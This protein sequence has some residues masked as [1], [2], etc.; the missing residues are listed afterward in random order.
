MRHQLEFTDVVG[1]LK[2][3]EEEIAKT[4]TEAMGEATQLLKLDLRD[5]VE[6]AGLGHRLGMA[7]RSN[8]YP[9]GRNSI[10]AA[11]YVWTKVPKIIDAFDRG[12][13]IRSKE[14]RWLAIP[15]DAAGKRAPIAGAA[16]AFGS[17]PGKTARVT[18]G[19]FE[20]R[21]GLKLRFIYRPG[22]PSLLVVDAA[23][24]DRLGRAAPYLGRGRGAKLYGPKGMT[25]VVFILVPQIT[26]RKRLKVDALAEAG[27]DRFTAILGRRWR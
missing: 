17:G 19:G 3:E 6:A 26:L 1:L 11:G 20:R 8:V 16:P 14:G 12:V 27:A 7:W 24:R 9:Q 18:P 4:V 13:T 22:K 21:T 10:D 25:I 15:T 23:Q 5:D 2:G